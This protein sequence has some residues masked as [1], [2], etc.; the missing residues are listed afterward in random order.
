MSSF[1]VGDKVVC[2]KSIVG[3]DPD[4]DDTHATPNPVAGEI[5]NVRDVEFFDDG[6]AGLYLTGFVAGHWAPAGPE[7]G[8][9]VGYDST[10]FR[11]VR[12]IREANTIT[13]VE[14]S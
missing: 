11:R 14:Q 9:E 12:R 10:Y 7:Q 5:Y 8:E 3:G 6:T 1:R 4:I 2:I 13:N